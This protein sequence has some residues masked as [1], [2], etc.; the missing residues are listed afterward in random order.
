[1]AGLPETTSRR[2]LLVGLAVG[3]PVIAYGVRG[4]LVDADR[5]HPAELA[6]WIVGA[7]VVNDALV[8]P[9]AMG[10]AWLARRITPARAWP[11]VRSGLLA[12]GVV[13]VV[14]WPF[15][16]GYGRDPTIPSL[17]E[18]NY[19]VGVTAAIGATWVAVAVWI[20]VSIALAIVVGRRRGRRDR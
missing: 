12:T 13:L 7:A 17:L 20:A 3:L 8:V 5:T 9:L 15:V 16:R 4:M 19:A 2:G 14:A 10:A 6:G 18:R 11:P 1:M